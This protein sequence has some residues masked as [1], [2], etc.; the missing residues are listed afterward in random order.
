VSFDV[1]AD[2]YW[3]FMGRFSEPLATIF[4]D[5]LGAA[6]GQRALD[7]GCGPGAL[8]ARLAER[9]GAGSVCAVD[10]S[11]TFVAATSARLPGVDVRQGTAEA[12][13][14]DDDAFDVV[15]AQLVVHFMNAP[16]VGLQEMGRV[17]R[18]SGTIGAC[19]WDHAGGTGP[20]AVFWD[21]VRDTDPG[22]P[23]E[24][25][26]PGTRAGHLGELATAAGL[27]VVDEPTLTVDVAFATFEDWWESFTLG[28]GPAGAHVAGL[29]EPARRALRTA[30]HD[31]L[32]EE[33][34]TITATAWCVL[35]RA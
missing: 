35:A 19:V 9:L 27:R 33:P 26:L 31:R 23:G 3:R 18:P 7:V 32:P 30:C 11:A 24:A 21:A 5:T 10:P 20:L 12:L 14:H 13:P 2:A 22:H 25:D 28:V 4:S 16:V 29:D 8:T 17:A 1:T 34:F 6:P 15:A